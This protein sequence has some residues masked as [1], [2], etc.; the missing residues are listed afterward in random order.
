MIPLLIL[1]VLAVGMTSI[2]QDAYAGFE[3]PIDVPIAVHCED[4]EIEIDYDEVEGYGYCDIEFE[5]GEEENYVPFVF[6]GDAILNNE[7]YEEETCIEALDLNFHEDYEQS[8]GGFDLYI[9]LDECVS[10]HEF[11]GEISGTG[12]VTD[13]EGLLEGLTGFVEFMGDLWIDYYE[14][15][16]E[17]SIWITSEPIPQVTEVHCEVEYEFEMI[18]IWGERYGYGECI[19]I[20][21]DGSEEEH[22]V[23][24]E[25]EFE[26]GSLVDGFRTIEGSFHIEDYE[27]NALWLFEEGDVEIDCDIETEE[28]EEFETPYCLETEATVEEGEGIFSFL[29]GSGTRTAQGYFTTEFIFTEGYA[30]S[31]I[32]IFFDCPECEPEETIVDQGGSCSNCQSPSIGVTERGIRVVDGGLTVNGNTVDADYY[33]TPYPLIHANILQPLDFVFKIWDDRVNNIKHLQLQLGKGQIGESF[34]K[35]ASA[36]WDRDVMT[37]V[38]TITHDPMFTNVVMERLPDQ[39]CKFGG[40]PCTVIHVRL[41]PTSPIVGDVVFGVNIW[42]DRRNAVTTFFNDGIQIGTEADIVIEE[43]IDNTVYRKQ[44]YTDDGYGNIDK[45][46]SEAFQMKLDWHNA[47]INKIVADLGY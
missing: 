29:D 33:K 47:Q 42:D 10:L 31:T 20:F 34:S 14:G 30:Y 6:W 1:A 19:Y 40:T 22:E 9:E 35:I 15:E 11:H 28:E 2:P 37:G 18:F 17:I 21:S 44:V 36:E 27:D 38:A 26:V 16:G 41:T 7:E 25:G 32:W 12:T 23:S 45:R 3:E 13:S 4:L 8:L 39:P 5:S 46:Y 43:P 24:V